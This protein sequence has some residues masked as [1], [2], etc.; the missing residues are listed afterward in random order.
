M[1]PSCAEFREWLAESLLGQAHVERLRELA[2]H[3]HLLGCASCRSLLDAEE[4]LEALLASLP[5]PRLPDGLTQRLLARLAQERE[6]ALDG[7]L[8]LNDIDVDP[9][10]ANSVLAGLAP[11]RNRS[12]E[13]A[14]L[15][16]LL[17]RVPA[18]VPPAGL[19]DGVLA[20]LAAERR[21]AP[22]FA[23]LR[24]GVAPWSAAAAAALVL[25][26][27]GWRAL[28]PSD[29]GEGV[30]VSPN[31]ADAS[32]EPE[33]RPEPGPETAPEG[34]DEELLASLEVLERWDLLFDEDVDVLLASLDPLA[35]ELLDLRDD[36]ERYDELEEETR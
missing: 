9:G 32:Q 34:E 16:A 30:E 23:L 2:W 27:F 35:D 14:R 10:L 31:V 36:E 33:P 12:A 6:A 11:A 1:N 3:E 29:G 13:L 28:R 21:P 17:D 24:G 4:A 8:D 7:L 20:G 18:P 22:R 19:A 26:F 5:E 25:A 15:D